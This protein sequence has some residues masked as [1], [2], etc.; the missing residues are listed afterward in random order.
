MPTRRMD[1]RQVRELMRLH[2]EAGLGIRETARR[3]GIAASTMRDMVGRFDRAGL[4]WPLATELSNAELEAKL[5]GVAGVKPGRRRLAEPDWA[6]VH[7][8][9]KRKHVTLQTLW[10]EYIEVHPQGYRYSRFCDLYRGWEGRLPVTMRQTH[11]AGD[12]LFVDYAGDKVPVVVDRLTREVRQAH[13]FVAVMGASSLS[14]ACATWS[15]TL[16]DWTDAHVQ[17]F[18]AFGGAPRLLVPDNAKVAVI[19]ACLYDPQVNRSYGDMARHY[20]T[21]CLPTRPRRPRDKAKVE[22]CVGIVE[23][24]LFGRLRNQVFYSLAEL[25]AAIAVLIARLNDERVMRQFGRTR[26]Q[27]FEELDAPLLTALPAEPYVYAE[28]RARRVGLDYHVEVEHHFYSV[29]HRYAKKPVEARFTARTVEIFHNGERIAVHMRGGGNGRH[30]T[31]PDH[32]PSSHRRFVGWTQEKILAEAERIGTCAQLLCEK[33]LQDRPHPEQGFR[34][35]MGIL[36][37]EKRFGAARLEAAA[38][39]ALEIGARN[40]PSVKSILE[41][42]LEG[43]P[44]PRSDENH[45]PI[46]HGN[47][48]G[49]GYYH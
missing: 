39:R 33:I 32:M 46:D 15:E 47:I 2:R 28:W 29:P 45:Q 24:W 40:Y 23:R 26:R 35:C 18:A 16:A 27:L 20:G 41:K 34:S 14:F 49:P 3:A 25:N 19:K 4:E 11:H 21:T 17:A 7:R 1:M 9:L 13:I 6:Y 8:E 10:E 36:G 22:A 12:K 37:L 42:Q 30:T 5:Y 31:V 44:L 38:L 48:R 43:Q